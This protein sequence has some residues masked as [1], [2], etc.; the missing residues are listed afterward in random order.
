MKQTTQA[1]ILVA[2]LIG[3]GCDSKREQKLPPP[4]I[5]IGV[6]D[7]KNGDLEHVLEISGTLKFLANTTVSA[8]VSAQINSIDVAD[9]QFVEAGNILLIFDE[10]KIKQSASEVAAHLQRDEA[11]LSFNKAEWEKNRGLH[12]T[13]SISQTQYDQKLSAYQTSLA[14]VE[15]DRASLAKALEDLTKTKAKAPVSGVV[16]KRYVEKG[17]W[18]SSGG[19]LFQISD[20]NRIY[21]E[22][23]LT[24][25]DLGKLP[26]KKIRDE[27]LPCKVTVD[28]Y[29]GTS[30]RGTLSY[31]QPVANDMRLFEV[32]I[33]LPNPD[34]SLLQGMV[35]RAR[36]TYKVTP[37]VLK[38]PLI[39]LLDE[40][41]NQSRNRVVLVDATAKARLTSIRIG[42]NDQENAEVLEGLKAGDKVVT[43]GKE[44]LRNDQPLK[45]TQ[46]DK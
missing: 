44:V 29:P 5:Q 17:D 18:V 20:F 37:D 19:K 11:I 27:G 38:V 26:L 33:Y 6:A 30:Y 35:G 15:A 25:V 31:V 1:L 14:Q 2:L 43:R 4:P 16:S 41:R 8:E 28:S 10:T 42:L 22:T 46:E 45:I 21:L 36:V 40:L 24:D 3:I 12:E 7:I 34:M 9:G 23:F 32:R 39:A 13:G